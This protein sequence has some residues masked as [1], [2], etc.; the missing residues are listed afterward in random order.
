MSMDVFAKLRLTRFD[1]WGNGGEIMGKPHEL[2]LVSAGHQPVA[3]SRELWAADKF[4]LLLIRV[5]GRD[6]TSAIHY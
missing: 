5:L 3:P 1:M 6:V 2:P 4:R